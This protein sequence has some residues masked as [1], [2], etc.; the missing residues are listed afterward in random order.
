[1]LDLGKYSIINV[2]E[3][4]AIELTEHNIIIVCMYR[5][6]QSNLDKF[7]ENLNNILHLLCL[8][9]NNKKVVL[10]GDFNINLLKRNKQTLDFKYTLL[11]YNL[12]LQFSQP[13]RLSSGTCL[14]NIAHNVKGCKGE[15]IEMG[16]SD[17]TAQFLK[18]PVKKTCV[19]KRW[20]IKRRNYCQDNVL[21][22]NT[23]WKLY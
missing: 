11:N 20:K 22:F 15:I 6:P 7:F 9:L 4:C 16:L 2:I 3:C 18:F 5:V 17:H 8:K 1:M 12:K 23:I 13:T 14:D 10:C 19:L 21:A